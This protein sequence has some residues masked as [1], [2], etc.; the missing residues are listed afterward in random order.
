[1]ATIGT[2]AKRAGCNVE[3]IRYY[4]RIGLLSMPPRAARSRRT[5]G[6]GE[7]RHLKF[8]RRCREL[9]FTLKDV[10]AL[11]ELATAA[12]ENCNRVRQLAEAQAT[13]V[14]RKMIELAQVENWL[15]QMVAQCSAPSH[16]GCPILD[17]L[18]DT[19][20]V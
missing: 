15:T 12:P 2:A 16:V 7:V 8:I 13:S 3:T 10:R 4:Q 19:A 1:M 6:D 9:G 5:Y 18:F 14:R 17:T 20:D 11:I